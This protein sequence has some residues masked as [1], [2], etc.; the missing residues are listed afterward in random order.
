[1]WNGGCVIEA[2]KGS[3]EVGGSLWYNGLVFALLQ[4]MVVH[5]PLLLL[6]PSVGS[7]TRN[8]A[9]PSSLSKETFYQASKQAELLERKLQSIKERAQSQSCR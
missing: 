7:R 4:S 1:M 6:P 9:R 3:I 8:E 2:R 5:M